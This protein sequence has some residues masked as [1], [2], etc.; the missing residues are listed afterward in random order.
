MDWKEV[1]KFFMAARQ[2]WN[3]LKFEEKLETLFK[4]RGKEY[5]PYNG[6]E[7][8]FHIVDEEFRNELLSRKIIEDSLE[9]DLLV[10]TFLSMEFSRIQ[11][12]R[13]GCSGDCENC[14]D[15][16]KIIDEMKKKSE[17]LLN[18]GNPGGI[19]N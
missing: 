9:S 7:N 1:V 11:S 3:E 6:T 4:E 17:E 14:S 2:L 10:I 15:G 18:F 5:N 13:K 16:K 19:W 12:K 8:P